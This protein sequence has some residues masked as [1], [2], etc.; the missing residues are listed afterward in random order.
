M[1]R[2]QGEYKANK[3][4]VYSLIPLDRL[5]SAVEY[6]HNSVWELF[7]LFGVPECFMFS[8]LEL[9]KQEMEN[10]LSTGHFCEAQLFN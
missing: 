4:A 7:E 1:T 9:Y 2:L 3:R 10:L 5:I 6:G 8:A